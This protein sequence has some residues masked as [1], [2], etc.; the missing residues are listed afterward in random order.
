MF[1]LEKY[2][3]CVADVLIAAALTK[4]VLQLD[5]VDHAELL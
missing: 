1:V 4:M 5:M 2:F 3:A